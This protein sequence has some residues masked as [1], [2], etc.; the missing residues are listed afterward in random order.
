MHRVF[1]CSDSSFKIL[2]FQNFCLFFFIGE[3]QRFFVNLYF[4]YVMSFC[5]DSFSLYFKIFAYFFFIEE[6]YRFFI[7]LYFLCIVSFCSDSSF[8][9][10]N[11]CLLFFYRDYS[12]ICISYKLLI[13]FAHQ[14]LFLS[15]LYISFAILVPFRNSYR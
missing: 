14:Y 1:F 2:E 12:L 11:F 15:F 3:R 8:V 13:L 6:K 7:N 5:S 10:Q 4:L 9:F